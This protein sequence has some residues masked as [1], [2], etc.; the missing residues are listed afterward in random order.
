MG[1]I[2]KPYEIVKKL[3]K[4]KAVVTANKV[5]LAYH[6]YEL[7][8]LAGDIPFEFEAAVAGGIPIINALRDGLTANFLLNL[9]KVLW[10]ELV[11]IC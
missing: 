9:F 11:T 4:G 8:E 2:E 5:L 1:G 10:M 7:Q 6:R 3:L